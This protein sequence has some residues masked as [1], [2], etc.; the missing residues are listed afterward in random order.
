MGE[1]GIF[2]IVSIIKIKFKN[3]YVKITNKVHI[4]KMI[5]IID[6]LKL[7]I[8]SAVKQIPID[9]TGLQSY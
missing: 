1:M 8:C 9:F 3:K 6:F 7:I 5:A 2:I 4:F